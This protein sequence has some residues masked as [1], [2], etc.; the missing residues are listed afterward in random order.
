[1]KSKYK[2]IQKRVFL[3]TTSGE[4]PG[5]QWMFTNCVLNKGK[6]GSRSSWLN[7]LYGGH[8]F[9]SHVFSHLHLMQGC[10]IICSHVNLTFQ[11][12]LFK[13]RIHYYS[14]LDTQA[15]HRFWQRLRKNGYSLEAKLK[16]KQDT[17]KESRHIIQGK[18]KITVDL[19]IQPST[20]IQNL[21]LDIFFR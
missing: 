11:T 4:K 12:E 2:K 6:L 5:T 19:F 1:M 20:Y 14:L 21:F 15:Q 13:S 18:M 17:K 8:H 7:S 16:S 9:T 10:V 3:L